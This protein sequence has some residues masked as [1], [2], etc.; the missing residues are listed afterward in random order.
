MPARSSVPALKSCYA[1]TTH[2]RADL[3]GCFI[4][5]AE[6]HNLIAP[7][8]RYVIVETIRQRHYFPINHQFH[9]GINVAAKSFPTRRA[10]QA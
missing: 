5:I 10:S 1:G 7:L 3:S 6:E 4:P 8:T 9:I 2:A